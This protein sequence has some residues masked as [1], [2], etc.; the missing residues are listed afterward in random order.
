MNRQI[1]ISVIVAET[2]IAFV[3]LYMAILLVLDIRYS[4]SSG[5]S[6]MPYIAITILNLGWSVTAFLGIPLR[7]RPAWF[8]ARI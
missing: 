2:A 1:P 3:I 8:L 5:E 4:L 7:W 6:G